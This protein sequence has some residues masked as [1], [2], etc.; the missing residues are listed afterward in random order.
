MLVDVMNDVMWSVVFSRGV[1]GGIFAGGGVKGKLFRMGNNFFLAK[2]FFS[3]IFFR[4]KFLLAKTFD[5]L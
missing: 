2:I 3:Q 1:V 4:P 5:M